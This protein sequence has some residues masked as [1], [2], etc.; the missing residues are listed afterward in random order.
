MLCI[1]TEL[2]GT[3]SLKFYI[4]DLFDAAVRSLQDATLE[5]LLYH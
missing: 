3:N 2:D 1:F 4:I 5:G